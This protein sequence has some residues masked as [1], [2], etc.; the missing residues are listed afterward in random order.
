MAHLRK[1]FPVQSSH[2][3]IVGSAV[4]DERN[5]VGGWF[6]ADHGTC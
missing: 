6:G 2:T 3:F 1:A 4:F 5:L